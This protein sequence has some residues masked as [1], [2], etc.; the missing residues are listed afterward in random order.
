M[1]LEDLF[2]NPEYRGFGI[3]KALFAE[4]AKVAE[5]KVRIFPFKFSCSGFHHVAQ[6]CARIDWSVLKVC[7]SIS[8]SLGSYIKYCG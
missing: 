4:L 1:K 5:E 2:V 8:N 6:D 3:G 7:I